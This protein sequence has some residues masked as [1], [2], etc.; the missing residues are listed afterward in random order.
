MSAKKLEL[1]SEFETLDVDG[2]GVV[3][4]QELRMRKEFVRLEN[5]DRMADQQRLMAWASMVFVMAVVAVQYTPLV[6]LERIEATLGFVN[7]VVLGQLGIVVSFMG[8]S[9]LQKKNGNGASK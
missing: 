7:T 3:S 4:D 5:E 9:A 1:G 6:S 2:D 8:F